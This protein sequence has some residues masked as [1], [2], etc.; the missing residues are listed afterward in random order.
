MY[1]WER[2]SAFTSSPEN[3]HILYF[4]DSRC[5]GIAACLETRGIA[6]F[7]EKGKEELRERVRERDGVSARLCGPQARVNTLLL[8][9][10]ALQTHRYGQHR[11]AKNQTGV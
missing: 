2:E 9:N 3:S 8:R 4:S 7:S 10:P 11:S 1:M 6:A 5:V